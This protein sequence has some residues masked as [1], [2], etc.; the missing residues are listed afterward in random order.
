MT[1]CEISP[2]NKEP[3]REPLFM[4]DME[5]FLFWIPNESLY[6]RESSCQLLKLACKEQKV[7]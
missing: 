3:P 1:Y 5:M 6:E 7:W 2:F 4:V